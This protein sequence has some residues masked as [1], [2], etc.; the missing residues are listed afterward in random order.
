MFKKV[1]VAIIIVLLAVVGFGCSKDT[2]KPQTGQPSAQGQLPEGH[3]SPTSGNSGESAKPVDLAEVS[4]KVKALDA[5]FAGD[6][7][8]SGTTLKKGAYVENDSYKI[9][10]E[11]G[12][13]YSGSMVSIF[14][15]QDRISSTVTD[16]TG[17]RVLEG[18]P[19]PDTVAKVMESGEAAVT[20]ADSMGSI[21][22]QKVYLPFKSKDGN[23]VAVMSVSLAQ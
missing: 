7:S 13:L 4:D 19:T 6:W 1:T 9:A 16:Q 5:K 3:P 15:G 23:I 14:V 20:S 17:K 8:V 2:E 11:V 22:Y 10:D 21:S 12:A 18:Y